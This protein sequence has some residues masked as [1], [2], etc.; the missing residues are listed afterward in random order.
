MEYGR[1]ES[2]VPNKK[3]FRGLVRNCK[4]LIMMQAIEQLIR[5]PTMETMSSIFM[6]EDC[7]SVYG[8]FN[9]PILNHHLFQLRT[10]ISHHVVI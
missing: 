6:N 4:L 3:M 2:T 10:F 5:M 8:I 1:L 7:I 9:C